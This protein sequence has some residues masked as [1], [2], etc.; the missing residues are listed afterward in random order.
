[1]AREDGALVEQAKA[2]LSLNWTG[3]Y[4]QP[5]P[6]LY[7]HQWS[8]D[9]A[10]IALAYVHY[11]RGRAER[12]LRH[13]FEAQ[14]SNGLLPQIVFNPRFLDYFP[15]PSFW[16]ANESPHAP[17][18]YETSGVVMPPIHATAVLAVHKAAGEKAGEKSGAFLEYAFRKLEA[19][20]EYLY[21]DRDPQGEGLVY[22]RHPWESGMDNSPMWDVTMQ[23]IHLRADQIPKY[24]RADVHSVSQQ[25][26]PTSAACDRFAYLVKFFAE[27]GYDEA[28]IREDCPFLVQDVLFNSVLCRAD[29]D[30]AE[31]AR[32]LGEDPAP[33]EE[34]SQKTAHAIEEKL[35]DEERGIYLDHDLISGRL[36]RVYFAANFSPLFAGIPSE[37]R[38]KRLV[39]ALQNDGFGLSDQSVTP[40]P[41]YDM[42]GFGYSPVQ[43]W[44]GPVWLNINWLLMH[45]LEDYG[46][47]EHADRLRDSIV[48]LCREAGFHEYFDP[49]TG[50]GHGSDLFSWSAALLIDV[51]ENKRA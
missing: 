2:I 12:E 24:Q 30:M 13:L 10:F 19:W 9:S 26:R 21:R 28:R 35:W 27:R 50:E 40:V 11:N 37:A 18:R 51:L 48:G 36:I 25:D 41:S 31:M 3:E 4:T 29:K 33:F 5:G 39:D 44:R 42:Q 16:N 43:Y 32:V 6:R 17:K 7:P 34:R 1:L 8:W 46:Y 38:A 15:G 49:V 14:W 22:I 20:H 45:G 47:R 23:R